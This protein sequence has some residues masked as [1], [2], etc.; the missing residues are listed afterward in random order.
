MN[1]SSSYIVGGY[2]RDTL[3]GLNSKDKDY[4]VVCASIADMEQRF[5]QRVGADF[6]VWLDKSGNEW[7]LARKER[8]I[9]NGYNDFEV[10][11]HEVTLEEDLSRRDFTINALAVDVSDTNNVTS[12]SII[13]FY[14]GLADLNARV[15]RHVS[16]AFKEDPVRIL[17]GARFLARYASLGFTMAP[18]T[19]ELCREM[20]SDGMLDS[21]TPE[22]IWTETK[23]A[24]LEYHSEVYFD[25]LID[26]G[27]IENISTAA[28]ENLRYANMIDYNSSDL[29]AIKWASIAHQHIPEFKPTKRYIKVARIARLIRNTDINDPIDMYHLMNSIKAWNPTDPV[30]ALGLVASGDPIKSLKIHRL[31]ELAKN[32]VVDCEPGPEYGAELARLRKEVITND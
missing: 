18:E 5:E 7:A 19:V 29:V 15:L 26:I 6:P 30:I 16:I 31:S 27:F 11:T 22:R 23:K 14:G 9:G 20:V 32:I 25:F 2:V 8:S 1:E 24:L 3:L 12:S 17:R 4:V 28:R 10:E 13:D 21:V